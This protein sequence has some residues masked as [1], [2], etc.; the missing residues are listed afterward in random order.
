[1]TPEEEAEVRGGTSQA[2]MVPSPARSC[3]GRASAPQEHL[4]KGSL[5]EGA[6][7]LGT[8][9]VGKQISDHFYPTGS[10]WSG[11]P[12]APGVGTTG[13]RVSARVWE[14]RARHHSS[15]H[16]GGG[17]CRGPTTHVHPVGPS[18]TFP[19]LCVMSRHLGTP[20]TCVTSSMCRH[21]SCVTSL[22]PCDII[23]PM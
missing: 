12:G 17:D 15:R 2:H 16:L 23:H 5:G 22:I 1:M 13:P 10:C 9:E 11:G 19:H 6:D 4:D 14:P 18:I 7:S 3:Q 20:H 8:G 21:P